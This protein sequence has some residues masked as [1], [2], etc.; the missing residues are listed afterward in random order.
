V[1]GQDGSYMLSSYI[2]W[3][4]KKF[5]AN[6]KA[7][8]D[9][10][11]YMHDILL[12]SMKVELDK[13][14]ESVTEVATRNDNVVYYVVGY[15]ICRFIKTRKHCSDCRQTMESSLSNLPEGFTASEFTK[16]KNKGK[17]RFASTNLFQLMKQVEL[18]ITDFCIE[19]DIYDRDA[20][21]NILHTVCVDSLPKVGCDKH[22]I[23]LMSNLI[24]DY[25]IIRFRFIGRETQNR[26]CEE[27]TS[28]KHAH[29]KL[30]KL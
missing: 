20:F 22:F 11:G 23:Q 5:K 26:M 21:E 13:A 1:D 12:T 14:N 27:N 4:T 29:S 3:L 6:S 16:L 15:L 2:D 17:L 25:M 18:I 9:L 19:G 7:N 30:S 28:K 10:K 24:Y 8:K